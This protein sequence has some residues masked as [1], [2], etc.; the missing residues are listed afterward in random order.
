MRL[1]PTARMVKGLKAKSD[2]MVTMN[3]PKRSA[4]SDS[5]TNAEHGG[6]KEQE[7]EH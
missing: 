2:W 4:V 5:G 1:M 6:G 3:L 7:G